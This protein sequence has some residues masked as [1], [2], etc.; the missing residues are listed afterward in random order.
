MNSLN[1]KKYNIACENSQGEFCP[2]ISKVD[3][4]YLFS[5]FAP[6]VFPNF[7]SIFQVFKILRTFDGIDIDDIKEQFCV[8]YHEL[9]LELIQ[10]NSLRVVSKN[11]KYCLKSLNTIDGK[12][13]HENFYQNSKT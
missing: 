8:N 13:C 9:D 4:F 7:N 3:M 12:K 5:E 11:K 10:N 2:V 6:S 1:Q